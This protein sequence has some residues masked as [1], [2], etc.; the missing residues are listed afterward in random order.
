MP[1]TDHN[2]QASHSHF[3]SN[4]EILSILSDRVD[5]RRQSVGIVAGMI[6][7]GRRRVV[8]YGRHSADNTSTPDGDSVFEIGSITKVY[9]ALLLADM[10]G[11]GEATF[12]EPVQDL[13]PSGVVIP[14]RNGRKITLQQL[15]T[16]LSGLPRMPDNFNGD[17]PDPYRHYTVDALY[18]F[19]AAHELTR[20]VDTVE[21]Y[22]NLGVGL[23]GHALTCRANKDYE[24]LIRERVTGPLGM[25]STSIELSDSMKIRLVPGHDAS[26]RPVP[27]WNLGPSPFAGAG[28]LR[29][30]VN[31][32]LTL[33]EIIFGQR[34]SSL[35]QAIEETMTLRQRVADQDIALGWGA[36]A[37]GDDVLY[38]HDGGTAGYRSMMLFYRR[39]RTGVVLM[40]NAAGD[41]GDIAHH[42]L[43]PAKPLN[44][45]RVIVPVDKA[46]L[47]SYTGRYELRADFV[48]IV[49]EADQHLIAQ[50]TGQG[51]FGIFPENAREF[52]ADFDLN[53]QVT[54]NV[55]SH[56]VVVSMT[57]R[58]HGKNTEMLKN[59]VS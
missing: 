49:T 10:V 48:I 8:S 50:A 45:A 7:G 40:S 47:Q 44:K 20:D 51:P 29:S 42:L 58:Q 11:R 17:D 16:H 54:F 12:D 2:T 37:L 31:D 13:L 36:K 21:E 28:A 43:N 53:V 15:S 56:G 33:M 41:V 27:G 35:D 1:K 19:L 5:G 39:A 57:L 59:R 23:L 52:F 3:P 38:G 4:D 14:E 32:Q 9:T 26:L 46:V 55:D 34:K 18:Q 24:T 22:S 6:D 30:T 25:H